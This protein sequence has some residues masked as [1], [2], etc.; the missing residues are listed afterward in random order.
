M[1]NDKTEENDMNAKLDKINAIKELMLQNRATAQMANETKLSAEDSLN[2]ST[3]LFLTLK[4]VITAYRKN[5]IG[6]SQKI[7]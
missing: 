5:M 4:K 1:K 2:N 7:K 6:L 3:E